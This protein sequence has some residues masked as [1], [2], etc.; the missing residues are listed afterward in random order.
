MNIKLRKE[1]IRQ[2]FDRFGVMPE[3][4]AGYTIGALCNLTHN[5][6]LLDKKIRFIGEEN[7]EYQNKC[8]AASCEIGKFRF[9]TLI[10]DTSDDIQEFSILIQ[11]DTMMTYALKLSADPEDIGS[12]HLHTSIY[13]H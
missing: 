13:S 10:A 7:K 8:W 1:I 9:I 12:M 3:R 11:M 6:Y 5:E 2:I 4:D